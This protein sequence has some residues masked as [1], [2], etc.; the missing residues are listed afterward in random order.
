MTD[1]PNPE[2][3]ANPESE[4]KVERPKPKMTRAQKLGL[5]ALVAGAS[6]AAIWAIWTLWPGTRT[7]PNVETSAVEEFQDREAGSPFGAIESAPKVDGGD[8]FANIEGA[9][10]AQR[11]SL[12]TR[13]AALQGEVK[14]LQTEL[15]DLATRADS[16]KDATAKELALALEKAQARNLAL[17]EDMRGQVDREIAALKADAAGVTAA[18]AKREAELAAKR[19]EREEQLAARI[20]SPSVVYDGGD[21]SG[22][23]AAGMGMLAEATSKSLDAV[24]RD[25][26]QSGRVATEVENAQV[27]ANPS[28][29][30][31]QGTMIEATL[32]NAVDSSLPGQIT[33]IVTRPVWSFDQAQILVPAGSRLFGEYSS[34]V[35]IGQGRILVAWT[36]LVTPDGQSVQMEA[37]GGDAQ[38]RSGITGKVKSRFA[39]RFGSAALISLL[40]AAPAVAAAKYT[41]KISSDT[42]ENIGQDLSSAMGSAVETYT[43]LPPVITVD[44]GAAITVM[45]DR[46][47]EFW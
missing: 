17:I 4:Y 30:V 10:A 34:E 27:I 13:N 2:T 39:A 6:I 26:V 47:L 42:A 45:V 20:A 46:D 41:S 22:A 8:G 9:L 35:A 43:N 38:G 5:A 23:A 14:R 32:E 25:F 33:A 15:G 44:P 24:G 11:E 18:N 16:E 21:K 29:T 7:I 3:P 28:N 19:A 36:R 1:L 31:L 40:G 37:F 12:E